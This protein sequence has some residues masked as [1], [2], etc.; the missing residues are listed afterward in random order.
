VIRDLAVILAD[1]AR[2]VADLGAVRD[3]EALFGPVA[4]DA[5]AFR[6]IDRIACEPELLE[7]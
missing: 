1:G 6:V 7:E 5:T 2:C 3:Q 4:A